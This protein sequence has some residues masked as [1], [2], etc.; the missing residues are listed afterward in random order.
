MSKPKVQVIQQTK[1]S[2]SISKKKK[3]FFIG[4]VRWI[5]VAII[6]L[7]PILKW[8]ISIDVFFQAIRMVYYWDDPTV[9]AGWTFLV[10]FTVLTLLT[11]VV[12]VYNPKNV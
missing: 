1:G 10:H 9:N 5:W 8:V 7:W 12:S 4:A 6:L 2:Q 3:G 11:Y